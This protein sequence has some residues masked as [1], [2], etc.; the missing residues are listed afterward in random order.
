MVATSG[1]VC[2]PASCIWGFPDVLFYQILKTGFFLRR[3][4]TASTEVAL[5]E[6][7]DIERDV[8]M[9]VFPAECQLLG[10]ASLQHL[11]AATSDERSVEVTGGKDLSLKPVLEVLKVALD[12]VRQIKADYRKKFPDKPLTEVTIE[13]K[14]IKL[15]F[16]TSS[17]PKIVE[18]ITEV[19]PKLVAQTAKQVDKRRGK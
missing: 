3:P 11:I 19:V 17:E 1:G 6:D 13:T 2:K 18:M 8:L 15:V 16:K 14:D 5:T 7:Q 4:L 10:T 9:A 12:A